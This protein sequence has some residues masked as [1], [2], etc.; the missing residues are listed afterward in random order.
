M[1]DTLSDE[2]L[3]RQHLL[4]EPNHCFETIYTR[5]VSKVYQQCLSITQ[6]SEK[7][8]DFTH[9][10]F[11]K[12]FDKIGA[13]Q[14]RSSFATWIYSIAYNYCID[15]KRQA[16]RFHTT[17]ID[18]DLE[19]NLSESQEAALQE[20]TLQLVN[21]ALATLSVT[22]QTML[23]QKYEEGMSL[24]ELSQLYNL[25]IS[26]VKMRLKRSREKIQLF[27]DRYAT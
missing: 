19:R 11:I 26:A 4:Q 5:Y 8:Q 17:I 12:V 25:K 13:F 27:Y 6:D 24:D 3:I 1:S 16:K 18:E 22:E 2:E 10:I 21:R 7:A 9:D 15:Q 20:E 14:Q 23:R